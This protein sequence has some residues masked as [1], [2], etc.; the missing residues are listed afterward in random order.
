[1][2]QGVKYLGMLGR[3]HVKP[4][5]DND[6]VWKLDIQQGREGIIVSVQIPQLDN[7]WWAEMAEWD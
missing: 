4:G 2:I 6:P 5:Q 1:M 7:M 3:I